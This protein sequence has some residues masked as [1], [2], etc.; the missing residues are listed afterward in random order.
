METSLNPNEAFRL[1]LLQLLAAGLLGILLRW[2]SQTHPRR[3]RSRGNRLWSVSLLL[4]LLAV[5]PLLKNDTL[6]AWL[7]WA[8]AAAA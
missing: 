4:E 5:A 2:W 6:C 3:P 7:R 8:D 1:L